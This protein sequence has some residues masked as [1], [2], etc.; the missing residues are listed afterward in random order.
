MHLHEFLKELHVI[1]KPRV[2]LEVGVQYGTSLVVAEGS[3]V[4]IGI[5]PQPLIHF[6]QNQRPNQVLHHI[7]SDTFF[8][9]EDDWMRAARAT[10]VSYIPLRIDLGFIDGL[11]LFEQA[12]RDFANMERYMVRGGVIVIDDVLPY[13]QAI[14]E[15]EQPP[16]DW[17][18]DVWKLIPIL[19]RWRRDLTLNII[20]TE[21]TGTLVVTGMGKGL[22]EDWHQQVY[23]PWFQSDE[24]PPYILDRTEAHQ[25]AEFL[26]GLRVA[27]EKSE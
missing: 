2:Y 14:A 17:T 20:N 22:G 27:L 15:R 25:P 7:T 6:S 13:S 10:G 4:A 12:L 11:H 26:H 8:R 3:E 18:G 5:D 16:G 21:P 23:T 1:L 19:R 24:V 9:R